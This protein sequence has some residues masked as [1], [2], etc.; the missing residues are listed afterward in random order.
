M[1]QTK[2]YRSPI[3]YTHTVKHKDGTTYT[4]QRSGHITIC[5][6]YD[7][8]THTMTYGFSL[9]T[10]FD[11]YDRAYG[12]NVALTRLYEGSHEYSGD[13]HI[14]LTFLSHEYALLKILCDIFSRSIL[15]HWAEMAVIRLI[16]KFA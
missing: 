8:Q 2:F 6:R 7:K 14:P 11:K 12:D 3:P 1:I 16:K 4:G 5:S 9:C 15:P 13:I 10:P